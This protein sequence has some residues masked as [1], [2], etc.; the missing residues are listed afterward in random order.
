MTA[1]TSRQ[2]K[3]PAKPRQSARAKSGN[4]AKNKHTKSLSEHQVS[5]GRVVL[6][7]GDTGAGKTVLAIHKAPRPILV[8]DC[9]TGLDSVYGTVDSDNID[10]WGPADDGTELSWEDMDEFRNYLIAGEWDKDYKVVVV[11]NVTAG[12]KPVI[13]SCIEESMNRMDLEKRKQRDSDVPSQQDWGK[14][15]RRLDRWVRDVKSIKRKGVHVI[16]TSGTREWLDEEAGY[17]KMMPDL[18]GRERNQIATHMDAVGWLESDEDGRRLH[19]APSGAYITKLRLPVAQFGN[20]P[21]AIEDPDFNKMMEAVIGLSRKEPARRKKA[22][23][24]AAK[25]RTTRSKK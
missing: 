6:I 3:R 20:I 22:A 8:L 16:F 4:A 18:E 17:T 9:D 25:K 21:T 14:I 7:H 15:Y 1:K 12:Q 23:P 24:K 5:A 13:T 19:L 2:I 11:D 10:V